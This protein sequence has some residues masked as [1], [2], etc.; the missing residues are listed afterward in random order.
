ME[1]LAEGWAHEQILKNYPQLTADDIQAVLHYAAEVL[2]QENVYA[3][4]NTSPSL[5]WPCWHSKSIGQGISAWPRRQTPGGAA[6]RMSSGRPGAAGAVW[7][8]GGISDSAEMTFTLRP[9]K[10]TMED[11]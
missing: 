10:A 2:K 3:P 8:Y 9:M 1:L 6:A 4:R 7:K 5:W 11:I